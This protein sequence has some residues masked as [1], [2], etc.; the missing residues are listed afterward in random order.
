MGTIVCPK[1]GKT[2]FKQDEVAFVC[3]ECGSI[4]LVEEPTSEAE[5][6]VVGPLPSPDPGAI[7][8]PPKSDPMPSPAPDYGKEP[9][10]DAEQGLALYGIYPQRAVTDPKLLKELGD[11]KEA[12]DNGWYFLK[13]KFYAKSGGWFLC[14]PII[15]KV[16]REEEGRL[17]LLSQ[18]ILELRRFFDGPQESDY[19][20][21]SIRKWLNGEFLSDAFSLDA[22]RIVP[23]PE[24]ED[25]VFLLSAA[26]YADP[27]NGFDENPMAEDPNR[28][29]SPSDYVKV[30]GFVSSFFTS[31]MGDGYGHPVRCYKPSGAST[32]VPATCLGGIRP[33][34]WIEA[35]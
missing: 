23:N 28:G 22:D 10:V 24:S 14:S 18:S 25:K 20:D 16:I 35:D 3:P 30:R 15:W 31:S 7:T 32:Q 1:C 11:L 26:E 34:I 4:V 21:S 27:A 9:V 12:T 13:G 19:R 6:L 33:A 17:L 2:I 5:E 29:A 8:L